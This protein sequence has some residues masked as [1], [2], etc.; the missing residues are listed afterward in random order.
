MRNQTNIFEGTKRLQMTE[1]IEL[2]RQSLLAYGP[3]H[4]HWCIAWSGGKDSST[5]VTLVVWMIQSGKIPA[6]ETLT[7]MYADTRLELSPL[8]FAAQDIMQELREIG[9]E[10]RTVMAPLEKRFMTYI[11]GR[12]VPPPNN[13]TFRW[14]TRQIKI[15]PMK[16]ELEKLFAEKEE[17]VLMLTGVRQGESA[18]RDQRIMM[19]C[20]KDGA[21]CGQG[22]Y[23][24][25]MPDQLCDTL[26]PI[27]HWRVCH[28][29]E[30]LKHWAPME[31]YGDWSTAAIADAYGGDEAE[32]INARTGCTGCPL[33]QKDSALDTVIKQPRWAYLAP[34]K[35]LKPLWR[36]LR[37]PE[38][39]LR[40]TGLEEGGKNKQRMGPL[41]MEARKMALTEVLAI[42]QEVNEVAVKSGRPAIDILSDKEEAFIRQCWADNVWPN[43]WTGE[44]PTADTPM[45]MIY[46]D[47][48]VQ[49]MLFA[50]FNTIFH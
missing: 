35:R 39:R 45:E 37:K 23:Q 46:R 19:S 32:E 15:D 34:L 40:K 10:V 29:W 22:W 20:G 43:K 12:G 30:W 27:L 21:E 1:G 38:N 9:I 5:L 8:W 11:L 31:E 36:E 14:C 28:V 50:E 17:K 4:K 44:E 13:N 25:T 47:G 7:V 26:A 16:H 6:P 18:I 42:Q 3:T 2:T 24:E 33:A 49:A 48:T 41:T